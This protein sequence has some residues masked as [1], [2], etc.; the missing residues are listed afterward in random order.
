MARRFCI[1]RL[2][3][4]S[5]GQS[6]CL[7]LRSC[8]A[9]KPHVKKIRAGRDAC[10][11]ISIVPH[12]TMKPLRLGTLIFRTFS[13]WCD[14]DAAQLGAALAYYAA[15]SITPLLT[16]V[17]AAAGSFYH[18]GSFTYIKTQLAGLVGNETASTLA[19]TIIDVRKSKQGFPAGLL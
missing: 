8:R 5:W 1:S 16:I 13:A 7:V 19:E 12:R 6:C 18:R 15:F 10:F 17:L 2:I 11:R 3:G 4:L 9:S 14:D